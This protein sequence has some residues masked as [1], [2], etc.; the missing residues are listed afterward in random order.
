MQAIGP[1][2]QAPCESSSIA[3]VK[4]GVHVGYTRDR[5]GAWTIRAWGIAKLN[6]HFDDTLLV[7]AG[8]RSVFRDVRSKCLTILCRRTRS[9]LVDFGVAVIVAAVTR[10]ARA[11]IAGF[12][13]VVA[14]FTAQTLTFAKRAILALFEAA[15]AVTVV[16]IID[17]IIIANPE[18]ITIV[19][20]A[21]LIAL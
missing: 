6:V 16:V 12:I 14:V 5:L 20:G 15:D 7:F 1:A 4:G 2:H 10:L 21:A 17:T 13:V 3:L 18:F 11:W 9:R 19:V 8:H